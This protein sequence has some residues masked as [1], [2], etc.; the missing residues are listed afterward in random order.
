MDFTPAPIADY[1]S[2]HSAPEPALL[3]ELSAATYAQM[4]DPQMLSG[5]LV[6]RL[7]AFVSRLVQPSVIV[8]VGTFTGYSAICLAEGLLPGGRLHTLEAD[9]AIG[10]FATTW[11]ARAGLAARVQLHLGP[12]LATLPRVLEHER[13]PVDLAFL[14]AHKPEYVDYYE[15]LLP[16][17]R[18]GGVLITD[19]VLWSGRV[20][21]NSVTEATTE[22]IRRY[23]AHVAADARVEPLM[24]PVRDGLL[25][26][27]KR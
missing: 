2:A 7:L 17:L 13:H 4:Q 9:E 25:L 22:A 8:E 10:T 1:C 19:N 20:V 24:L 18:P 15:L 26:V 23:N 6:G 16:R 12:A 11:L 21:D 27:R 5:H 14:D 3:R